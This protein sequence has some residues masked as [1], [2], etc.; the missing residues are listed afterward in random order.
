MSYAVLVGSTIAKG[1]IK[2]IDTK[3][4]AGAPGV[5]AVIS[6]LNSP[7]VPGFVPTG[8]DP[9]QPQTLGGRLKVFNDDKV[10][11][12]DQPIAVVVAD[13][14]ERARFA[15]RLVKTQY[16]QEKHETDMAVGVKQ[17]FVPAQAKKTPSR[18]WPTTCAA[19]PMPTK[20]ARSSLNRST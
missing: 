15:A 19:R 11:F 20:R 1:R 2:S 9:S 8:K 4:A 17:G 14:L 18:R 16:E 7:K 6:H 3:A 13:T 10:R 5:L 12:N